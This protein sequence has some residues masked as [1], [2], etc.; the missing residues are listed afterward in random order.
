MRTRESTVSTALQRQDL[1]HVWTTV[2]LG[3][4]RGGRAKLT[5]LRQISQA[6][7]DEPDRAERLMPVLTVAIRSVRPPEARAGLSAILSAVAAR[8]ELEAMLATS[9]SR[10]AAHAGGGDHE[11]PLRLSR[12]QSMLAESP[13]GSGQ[14]LSM[15]PN[16]TREKVSFDAPLLHPLRFREAIERAARRG[17]QRPAFQAARQDRPTK[18]GRSNRPRPGSRS[19]AASLSGRRRTWRRSAD[20]EPPPAGFDQLFERTASATGMR[21]SSWPDCC[22]ARPGTVAVAD[23]VRPGDHRRRRRRVLRVLLGR[24]I[25]LRLPDRLARWLRPRD[26]AVQLGTTNV[27]YSWDLYH[28]FQTLRSYRETRFSIDPAGFEVETDAAPGYRE[29][30]IDLPA[31]WLRGLHDHAGGDGHARPDGVSLSRE[32]VYS[33]LALLKRHKAKKSPR[34]VRFELLPGKPP[35]IV[36]EPWEQRIVSYGTTYDGPA[37]RADPHLGRAAAAGAGAAAA[38]GGAVRRAPPGHRACRASG[39]RSMGEM[40]LTL[41][42]SGWTT[43]DWTRGSAL[44]LLAPPATITE[45]LLAP[46]RPAAAGEAGDVAR[47][48]ASSATCASAPAVT[49]AL[50]RLA[51][52][53]QVIHDLPNGVYRFRQVMPMPLGEAQLGPENPELTAARHL[54]L[55]RQARSWRASERTA[56]AVR[57][58]GQGRVDAGRDSGRS[59]RPHPPRQVR[60]RTFSQVRHSQR[61]VPAHDRAAFVWR[62]RPTGRH[63]GVIRG[64]A[65]ED[66]ELQL[67]KQE[68]GGCESVY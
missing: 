59:G 68:L 14:T 36:L 26:A 23:A 56:S 37:D 2:L 54:L 11:G 63:R 25:E 34:A 33:V 1:T 27:D 48:V 60:V 50:R 39:S 58:D 62:R 4:H 12:S 51:F 41:G 28:H 32:A 20:V 5:A 42:L 22:S 7:A 46:R 66:L 19:I 47:A 40:R 35:T 61:P 49:A 53:G 65:I 16:L 9:P 67:Q 31:G 44:D 64:T 21:G 6:I 8:P 17:D 15:M 3:V 45:D 57:A 29:E 13:S 43:N 38:A 18:S 10:T 52:A 24:R 30:K 55:T